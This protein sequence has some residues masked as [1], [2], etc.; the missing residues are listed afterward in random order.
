MIQFGSFFTPEN[1]AA[2]LDALAV[3]DPLGPW[4]EVPAEVQATVRANETE[5][6]CFLLN[7]TREPKVVT[8]K[9]STVD[10]LEERKLQGRAEISPY[11]VC[12]VR[13]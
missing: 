6:F 11:G 10:L 13:Y 12:L 5:R 3:Q 7:F 1:A 8:F 2:L 4:A 9:E